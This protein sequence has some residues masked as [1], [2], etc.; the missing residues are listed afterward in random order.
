[1]REEEE[2]KKEAGVGEG[3][4]RQT[5]ARHGGSQLHSPWE[6]RQVGLWFQGQPGLHSQTLSQKKKKKKCTNH[7][8]D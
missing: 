3:Q 5:L 4:E 8:G 6:K 7:F 1:M 2:E